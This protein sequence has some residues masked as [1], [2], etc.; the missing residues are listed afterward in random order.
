MIDIE[1]YLIATL[2]NSPEAIPEVSEIVSHADFTSEKNE[3]VFQELQ[4]M[5]TEGI[6]IDIATVSTNLI[7]SGSLKKVGGEDY[8]MDLCQILT[9]GPVIAIEYAKT[10]SAVAR[11]REMRKGLLEALNAV[12]DLSVDL[13]KISGFAEAVARIGVSGGKKTGKLA[14]EYLPEVFEI[15]QRQQNGEITGVATGFK[16]LDEHLSGLQKSDLIIL[17]G[18]PRMGKTALAIDISAN[19]AIEQGKSVIFFSMEMAARQIV[20]RVLFTR[21]KINGQALRRG[22]LPTRDFPKLSATVPFIK[23]TKWYVDGQTGITPIQLF[24][25]CK[26]FQSNHG[27]DLVVVDN[28]QKMKSAINFGGNKRLEIADITNSLKN[29]AK[30]L[31]VPILAISHLSR[32]PDKRE[33]PRPVLSDL[34]ESGNIEQDADIVMFIYREEV[35]KNV[36]DHEKGKTEL[37]LSKYRNGSEGII[38][39]HFNENLSSFENVINQGF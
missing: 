24:S 15:M 7:R 4:K 31:D 16:K 1:Q 39:L 32:G 2:I 9:I 12:N 34:Q 10:V 36:L 19:V 20:E 5:V 17:G 14:G 11:R 26:Q 29:F 18:R 3:L 22:Q 13:P 30:D 37:I 21:S 25:K 8:L 27:L 35:Y 38:P 23:K 6:A 33:D 28:I